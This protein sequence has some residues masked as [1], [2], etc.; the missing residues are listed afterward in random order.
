M[1]QLGSAALSEAELADQMERCVY[2]NASFHHPDHLR[3]AWHYLRTLR[4]SAAGRM[5]QTIRS[6]AVSLSHPE[7]YHDTVTIAW[8]RLVAA[9]LD[10]TPQ[11]DEFEP[12]LS[13]HSWLLDRDALLAF[14]SRDLLFSEP[15]RAGWVEPDLRPLPLQGTLL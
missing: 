4:G 7:K 10:C 12:F 14:Y 2:P 8:M 15:A 3:L 5:R 13:G 11:L 9:A 1:N 6:F